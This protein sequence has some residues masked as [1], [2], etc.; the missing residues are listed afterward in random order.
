MFHATQ[1]ATCRVD[2]AL[3]FGGA[4]TGQR[5]PVA[6][7]TAAADFDKHHGAVGVAHNQVYFA[8]ATPG[9]AVIALQQLQTLVLQEGQGLVLGLIALAFAAAL[10]CCH[11]WLVFMLKGCH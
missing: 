10:I 2:N 4:D 7:T 8:T 11:R 5:S 3:A 1:I 9:C 6:S